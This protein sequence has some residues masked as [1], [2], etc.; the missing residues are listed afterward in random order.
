MPRYLFTAKKV[1]IPFITTPATTSARQ[2]S[3]NRLM[4]SYVKERKKLL[5]NEIHQPHQQPDCNQCCQEPKKQTLA[6]EK[7]CE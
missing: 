2:S 4:F 6:A 3:R 5:L 7:A 1:D